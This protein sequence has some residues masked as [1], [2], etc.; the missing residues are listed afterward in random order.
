MSLPCSPSFRTARPVRSPG[1]SVRAALLCG[2]ALTAIGRPAGA[3]ELFE[4]FTLRPLDRFAPVQGGEDSIGGYTLLAA[5]APWRFVD[6]G[7]NTAIGPTALSIGHLRL[8]WVEDEQLQALL[9]VRANLRASPD[10]AGWRG[11]DCA[12]DTQTARHEIRSG[13]DLSCL[14]L[15]AVP[16]DEGGVHLVLGLRHTAAGGRLHEQQLL[17]PGAALGLDDGSPADW[18]PA[19]VEADP[20][21]RALRDRLLAWGRAWQTDELAVFR[22]EARGAA[23]WRTTPALSQLLRPQAEAVAA[24]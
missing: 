12:D 16:S 13:A 19:R 18:L 23:A 4:R 8:A 21:R 9:M 22:G 24:P 20:A 17:L 3:T 14:W 10:A 11:L 15:Q 5:P 2:L 6:G 1:R 7:Q